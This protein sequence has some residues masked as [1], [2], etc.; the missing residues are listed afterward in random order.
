M[1]VLHWILTG[2]VAYYR[3]SATLNYILEVD[4][5]SMLSLDFWRFAS[6]LENHFF[7]TTY[8]I[9]LPITQI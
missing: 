6:V 7:K 5:I 3:F 2:S 8:S 4:V 9:F 1:S